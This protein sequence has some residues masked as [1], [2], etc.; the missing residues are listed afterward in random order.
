MVKGKAAGTPTRRKQAPKHA[1]P[2]KDVPEAGHN[3]GPRDLTEDEKQALL[4]HVHTPAYEKA[5]A[6]L[7]KAQADFKNTSK[8]IKAEGGDPADCKL[9]IELREDAGIERLQR[10]MERRARVAAYVGAE[11]G[12][13]FSL[14]DEVDRT[15][16]VDKAFA[17]GKIAGMEGKDASPPHAVSTPQGQKWLQGWHDGQRINRELLEKMSKPDVPADDEFDRVKDTVD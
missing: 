5:L 14:L 13:Q 11:I 10:D 1:P 6:A 3:K 4:L 12:T 8:L 9:V 17:A 7:K 15:P 2:P 16:A